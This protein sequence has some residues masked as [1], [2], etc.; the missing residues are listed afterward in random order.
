[1]R[2]APLAALIAALCFNTAASAA[3]AKI[4]VGIVPGGTTFHLPTYVAMERGFFKKEGLDATWVRVGPKAMVTAGITGQ[5]DFV[6]VTV[7]GAV[8]ALHGAPI[9]Y[10][11]GQSSGSPWMIVADKDINKPED[12]RGKTIAY[13]QPATASYDEGATVLSRFFHMEPG[14]DYK[15]ISFQGQPDE[16]AALEN[17]NV[18]AALLTVA[19]AVKAEKAG[20]RVIIDTGRYMPRLAG[21]V[22]AIRPFVEK[23]PETVKAFIRAVADAILY[24]RDNKQGTMPIFK[25]YLGIDDPEEQ[26]LLW[27]RLHDV[28]DAELPA[29]PFQAIF[30]SSRL[31]MIGT[32]QWPKDKPL[33][34]TETF[35]ARPLLDAALKQAHY[36]PA[37]ATLK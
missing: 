34:D 6:P 35:L 7:G 17:G 19:D 20:F 22:W 5:L 18:Q 31:G 36:S 4:T 10:V 16:I 28:F 25:A 3:P 32:G 26:S 29:K 23:N 15:V 2:A 37:P 14:K 24:I 8:A 12:L 27:D 9:V 30:E 13:G 21:P 11:V 33:P 1:M